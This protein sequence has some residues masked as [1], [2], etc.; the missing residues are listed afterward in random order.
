MDAFP[1]SDRYR[2]QRVLGTGGSGRVY[3]V[4]DATLQREVALKLFDPPTPDYEDTEAMRREFLLLGQLDHPQLTRV[5]DVGVLGGRPYLTVELVE[6]QPLDEWVSRDP[7]RAAQACGQLA[8]ALAYVHQ[9]GIVHLDVKPENALMGDVCR[10]LDFGLARR[11]SDLVGV[12]GTPAFMAPEVVSGRPVDHRADLYS[13]GATLYT[14]VSG[15]PP[16][17]GSAAEV[18]ERILF[19]EPIALDVLTPDCPPSL[20]RLCSRLLAKAPADRPHSAAELAHELLTLSGL[21]GPPLRVG[22]P[23]CVGREREKQQLDRAT[24]VLHVRGP[25]GVGKRY[26]V[27]QQLM[28]DRARG[29]A[30]GLASGPWEDALVAAIAAAGGQVELPTVLPMASLQERHRLL[31]QACQRALTPEMT[32]GLVDAGEL[33]PLDTRA[34]V[35]VT[36]TVE[37]PSGVTLAP[38]G[39]DETRRFL[40]GARPGAAP[41][42]AEV[43]RA[44]ARTDGLPQS[45]AWFVADPNSNLEL[46]PRAEALDVAG[47]S[48]LTALALLETPQP[49]EAILAVAAGHAQALVELVRAGMVRASP[50]GRF[51][52]SPPALAEVVLHPLLIA[53]PRAAALAERALTVTSTLT[54][55]RLCDRPAELAAALRQAAAATR[56]LDTRRSRLG[57]LA[58]LRGATLADRLA[59]ETVLDELGR[60]E[61]QG[62]LLATLDDAAEVFVRRAFHA[63]WT[64]EDER[65]HGDADRAI[66]AAPTPDTAEVAARAHRA[67]GLVAQ[68]RGAY[69]AADQCFAAA[70]GAL[71]P[72][73]DPVLRAHTVHDLGTTALYLGRYGD[74]MP[75]FR[76]SLRLKVQHGDRSGARIARQN[77]G[78]CHEAIDEPRQALRAYE[79]ALA[80]ARELGTDRGIAWNHMAL[81]GLLRRLGRRDEASRHLRDGERVAAELGQPLLL[82]G[83]TTE[84]ALLDGTRARI[85]EAEQ[86]VR[87]AGDGYNGDRLRLAQAALDLREGR[88][89]AGELP[90]ALHFPDRHAALSALIQV[91][92]GEDV[93]V[94]TSSEAAAHVAR[95]ERLRKSERPHEADQVLRDALAKV[96]DHDDRAWLL[97]A[98][99]ETSGGELLEGEGSAA[100]Q[101]LEIARRM[102]SVEAS[103]ELVELVL[104]TAIELTGAE[105]GFLLID[106]ASGDM[107]VAAARNLD[108]ERVRGGLERISRGVA[109]EVLETGEP[110]RLVDAREDSALE[111]NRSIRELGLK[112][113]LCVPLMGPEPAPIGCLYLDHRFTTGVFGPRT[114][115]FVEMLADQAALALD[116]ARTRERQ[117]QQAEEL[118]RL[119]RMLA[120]QE[121]QTRKELEDTRLL[122]RATRSEIHTRFPYPGVVGR[123]RALRRALGVLDRVIPTE[124]SVLLSGESGTGK[125]LLA[126]AVHESSPRHRG[127]WVAVNCGAIPRELLDSSFFGH[128]RGAF[129]GAETDRAGYFA[130]ADQ[131]TIFLDEIGEL[132]LEAQARLLRVLE[133]GTFW[134]VGSDREQRTSA[135][136]VCATNRDL[137][138]MCTSGGFR[139]DLYFRVAQ[140]TVEVPPLRDRPEDVPLLVEHFLAGA[141]VVPEAARALAGYDWPG[142]VRELKNEIDRAVALSGGEE[143]GVALLTEAVRNARGYRPMAAGGLP[144]FR[145]DLKAYVDDIERRVLTQVVKEAGGNLTKAAKQLGLSRFGLRKKMVR[146]GLRPAP[147]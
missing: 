68:Q 114:V 119:N 64:G 18:I 5:F 108:Q 65:A 15:R 28:V 73:G 11:G 58:G 146:L 71:Q 60:R 24:G 144:P 100:L 66:A 105:R 63:M 79:E 85:T 12:A 80:F 124:L 46:R 92:R 69:A 42:D 127:P 35:L 101:I 17:V 23:P 102:R 4:I 16:F 47:R 45:L 143:I 70:R 113:V 34:R 126:K 39:H 118:R 10:L 128:K 62:R 97:E 116:A 134:P 76:E 44:I 112:S 1:Q 145:G 136:V 132:P 117:A 2:P 7:A 26:L 55:L 103:A 33:P 123:S 83:F 49:A 137:K 74:A 106:N 53:E 25:K 111:L 14:L 107:R 104:D 36:T 138:A 125:E 31:L 122:L 72:G 130:L 6:G 67:K 147:T 129:T 110:V 96:W 37:G 120:D 32:I 52:L 8:W 50:D 142:N 78:I 81:G 41:S 51:R 99:G 13:L 3:A 48:L 139:E 75:Y 27:E 19:S 90:G 89:P 30:V 29:R 40:A 84:L 61:Q 98:I 115:R 94:P 91:R 59:L 131:G 86:A 22:Q 38:F 109:L 77:L 95:A 21:D 140:V 87:S 93:P 54:A 9:H 56:H 82:A 88:I 57:E 121:Q 20:A 141:A 135:R 43:A 133:T